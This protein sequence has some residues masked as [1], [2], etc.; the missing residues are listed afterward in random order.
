VNDL[1]PQWRKH[2]GELVAHSVDV[3]AF[4]DK[5]H[6][7]VLRE[8]ETLQST[9]AKLRSFGWFQATT[10]RDPKGELRP[11]YVL[12]FEGWSLLV[13]GFTGPKAL[14]FKISWIEAFKAQGGVIR[15]MT[16]QL[17]AAFTD[18]AK[19]FD[20]LTTYGVQGERI[21]DL[22]GRIFEVM[23]GVDQK[24]SLIHEGVSALRTESKSKRKEFS[25]AT[26]REL[27]WATRM[28]GRRCP[29]CGTTDVVLPDGDKGPG[30]EFD[31]FFSNHFA[32]PDSGW[33]ICGECHYR[34]T[35]SPA[36]RHDVTPEF[37]A[38]QNKRKALGSTQ[39]GL[40]T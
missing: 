20:L 39:G 6:A 11:A 18:E 7:D 35:H 16:E 33:L 19:L 10:Y 32:N 13:M 36:L 25:P 3:A 22:C 4:F 38:F 21:E 28:L 27:L 34:L 8:I 31:H 9:N 40:F 2:D 37:K 1:M 12:S 26:K 5:R 17:P 29:C 14:D 23:R 15:L 30:A 24:Q